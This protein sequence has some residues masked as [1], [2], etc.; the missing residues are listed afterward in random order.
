MRLFCF[1]LSTGEPVLCTAKKKSVIVWYL[2]LRVCYVSASVL[3]YLLFFFLVPKSLP[4]IGLLPQPMRVLVSCFSWDLLF[5]FPVSVSQPVVGCYLSQWE[6]LISPGV[7]LLGKPVVLFFRSKVRLVV[8]QPTRTLQYQEA[9]ASPSS[10]LKVSLW[11]AVLSTYENAFSPRLLGSLLLPR[12]YKSAC[13]WLFSQPMRMLCFSWCTE[14]PAGPLPRGQSQPVIGC[15]L[16]L[17]ECCVSAGV[18]GNLL[19]LYLL[20]KV[21]LWL[22]VLSTYENDFFT[23]VTRVPAPSS[24]LKVGL[25]LAVLSTYE[26][27]FF[28]QHC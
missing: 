10:C 26:N 3:G 6:C 13:D 16:N 5:L 27:A 21:S 17:W 4:V 1:T 15:S 20:A 12:V 11:L 24:C 8:S 25:W 18:L 14:E 9:C 2:N 23:Q 7:L 22:V 28:T 19:V